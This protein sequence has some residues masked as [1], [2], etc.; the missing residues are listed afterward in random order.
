MFPFTLYPV[1]SQMCSH[2]LRTLSPR[3]VPTHSV[4][5]CLPDM[6][7]LI[8]YL[9]VYQTCSHSFCTLLSLRRVPTQSI[10]CCLLDLF[11]LTLH[12]VVSQ[13]S[14]LYT[15]SS[16]SGTHCYLAAVHSHSASVSPSCS[17]CGTNFSH[18]GSMSAYYSSQICQVRQ[19][20]YYVF[21]N[22]FL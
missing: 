11:P 18:T 2:S 13:T 7:P 8:P 6:L 14:S 19:F 5:C 3:R 20:F 12:F 16:T 9:V 4:P 15:R 10:P 17:N 21:W 22:F 1:I